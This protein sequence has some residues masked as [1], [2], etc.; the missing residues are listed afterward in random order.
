MEK[1]KTEIKPLF[2]NK[3]SH[4]LN[5]TRKKQKPNVQKKVTVGNKKIKQT[6]R[7]LKKKS[8]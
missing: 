4:A 2:G 3:R 8:N 1:G 6:A 7:Q 5:A